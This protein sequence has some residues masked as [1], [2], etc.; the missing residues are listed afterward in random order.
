MKVREWIKFI[1]NQEGVTVA[2]K[3]KGGHS[4]M[5][6][7]Y[8]PPEEAMVAFDG[9]LDDEVVDAFPFNGE[10]K[11]GKPRCLLIYP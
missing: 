1:A 5:W 6:Y 7:H 11:D 8:L 2:L 10:S 9:W 3:K 4:P